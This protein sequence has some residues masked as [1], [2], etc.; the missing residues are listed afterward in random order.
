MSPIAYMPEYL[1]KRS[2]KSLAIISHVLTRTFAAGRS[3]EA[4]PVTSS[5]S[6]RA[7]LPTG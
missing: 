3:K 2:A 7:K 1:L 5:D 6:G 4:V